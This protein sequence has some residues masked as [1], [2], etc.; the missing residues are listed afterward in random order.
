MLVLAIIPDQDG[1][2]QCQGGWSLSAMLPNNASHPCLSY[3]QVQVFAIMFS[4]SWRFEGCFI[5]A[6]VGHLDSFCPALS[7]GRH[8]GTQSP[9]RGFAPTAGSLGLERLQQNVQ[10]HIRS[11]VGPCKSS[12]MCMEQ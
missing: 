6:C 7:V 1:H 2:E 11:P 10:H 5:R 12:R 9:A 4:P 8:N 3:P